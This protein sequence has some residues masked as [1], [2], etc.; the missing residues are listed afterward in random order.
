MIGRAE[1]ADAARSAPATATPYHG[2]ARV[3]A[4]PVPTLTQSAQRGSVLLTGEAKKYRHRGHCRFTIP[5][6]GFH[7][8]AL[9][10]RALAS[11]SRAAGFLG[12]LS[13]SLPLDQ[14]N[15]R[16]RQPLSGCG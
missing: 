15:D 4:G 11:A 10:A 6:V 2:A 14:C 1:I 5:A 7:G 8:S 13:P 3:R 9:I 16:R 12:M